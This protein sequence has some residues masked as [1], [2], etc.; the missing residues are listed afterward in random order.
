SN[1]TKDDLSFIKDKLRGIIDKVSLE[2]KID[3]PPTAKDVIINEIIKTS[4]YEEIPIS[5]LIISDERPSQLLDLIASE[6]NSNNKITPQ[7]VESVITNN[8]INEI[9]N[10]LPLEIS[11]FAEKS[12]IHLNSETSN[13]IQSDLFNITIIS[14]K[15]GLPLSAI[16]QRNENYL[17]AIS[18]GLQSIYSHNLNQIE[19]IDKLAPKTIQP[20]KQ[21]AIPVK[22]EAIPAFVK[23]PSANMSELTLSIDLNNQA[24]VNIKNNIL[25]EIFPSCL[26]KLTIITIPSGASVEVRETSLGV[27]NIKDKPFDPGKYT[28]IFKLEGHNPIKREYVVVPYEPN[29]KLVEIF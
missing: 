21:E 24:Y 6:L 28:F 10:N 19:P 16:K 18:I 14:A 11:K 12:Q 15:S 23:K 3:L 22:Q 5:Q 2:K 29:Q 26:P 9:K 4:I 25:P 13:L 27:T 20:L 8:K 7:F 1:L 17:K